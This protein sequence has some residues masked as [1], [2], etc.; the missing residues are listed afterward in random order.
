MPFNELEIDW[1]NLL[2]RLERLMSTGEQILARQLNEFHPDLELFR[3]HA[4]F[5]W[6]RREPQGSGVL[7]AVAFPDLPDLAHLVGIDRALA[8]LRRNTEQFVKGFS[9]NNVLLWGERG[10]GKSSAVKGLLPEFA[11]EGLRLVEVRKEDLFDLP[12]ITDRLRKLPYRFILFCDDLSFDETEV[13][14]R[15]LKALLEGGI[16][17]RPENVLVYATSNRRHLMPE[18]FQENVGGEEIHPEET[19]S[20]KLSLSDRFGITIGFYPMSQEIFL[21]IVRHHAECRRLRIS[22]EELD[23]E[24]LQWALSRGARSGRV[25]RQFIDDLSGRLGLEGK[26]DPPP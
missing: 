20:E 14:Y 8:R 6:K 1:K 26:I 3:S 7:T 21:A 24:A 25:A 10:G 16:Q 4:A 12:T 5:L 15:E 17:A 22:R 2:Q 23:Q 19:V 11:A 13:A 18:R 9:A